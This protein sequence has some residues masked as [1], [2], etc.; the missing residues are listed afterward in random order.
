[1]EE[2]FLR[3]TSN[4]FVC[5]DETRRS[6]L[7]HSFL[8]ADFNSLSANSPHKFS[9]LRSEDL[10]GNLKNSIFLIKNQSFVLLL[11]LSCWNFLPSQ[12]RNT[13]FGKRWISRTRW[14]DCEFV[15]SETNTIPGSSQSHHL[16][17]AWRISLCLSL[18]HANNTSIHLVRPNIFFST[19][20]KKNFYLLVVSEHDLLAEVQTLYFES[21]QPTKSSTVLLHKCAF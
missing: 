17:G 10:S 3:F 18:N 19:K 5:M 14:C 4:I 15:L 20:G 13:A 12:A 1:M 8:K 6:A 7:Y 2:H 16:V 11:A 21:L 9:A